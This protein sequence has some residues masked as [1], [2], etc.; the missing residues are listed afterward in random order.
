MR[1][2]T[3]VRHVR[4]PVAASIL[5]S[6]DRDAIARCLAAI[7]RLQAENVRAHEPLVRKI[8]GDIWELRRESR[9]TN[10]VTTI[11]SDGKKVKRNTMT[12][13]KRDYV[14][15]GEVAY[16]EFRDQFLSVRENRHLYE[17]EATKL[18]LWLQLVEARQGAGLTQ[19]QM[20]KRMGVS[21]AQVARIEKR[22][23]DAYTLNTL[24]RYVNALGEDFA[25][26]VKVHRRPEPGSALRPAGSPAG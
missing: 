14:R 17:E 9:G 11:T 22:G 24:R 16:R 13:K 6:L 18:D 26:E 4:Y 5:S 3:E 25:L 10:V 2:D 19:D 12:G 8:E 21:Q 20:A 7:D 15:E 1:L 23:Y